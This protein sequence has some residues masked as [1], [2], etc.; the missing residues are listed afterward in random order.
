MRDYN[1]IFTLAGLKFVLDNHGITVK[2]P[3]LCYRRSNKAHV[4][5]NLVAREDSVA[6]AM[7]GTHTVYRCFRVN[8]N[9]PGQAVMLDHMVCYP[10]AFK[11]G[12][13]HKNELATAIRAHCGV[14]DRVHIFSLHRT[15]RMCLLE[16]ITLVMAHRSQH[17]DYW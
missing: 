14:G 6:A 1:S 2:E 10:D 15:V 5:G 12:L 13:R 3:V 9:N 8:I 16:D 7:N 4:D 11:D 17:D